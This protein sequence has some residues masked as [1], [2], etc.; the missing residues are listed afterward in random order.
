MQLIST[1]SYDYRHLYELD[2]HLDRFLRS[3]SMA[4]ISLPFDRSTIRSILIQTVAASNCT[5]G[6]LRYWLSAGPGN[7]LLS[8][9]GCPQPALYAVVIQSQSPPDL[10]GTKV[11]TSS[12]PVKS[13]RFAIMK[14]VNYLPNV[15]S[16][17]EAEES[18]AF[19]AIWLDDEGYVAEG[20]NMNVGFV[21]KE[22]E[23]VVPRFEKVTSHISPYIFLVCCLLCTVHVLMPFNTVHVLMSFNV[24]EV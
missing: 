13:P 10:K 21:T 7:F 3:A 12:I 4:K 9:S 23:F 16:K 24:E 20:P 22:R 17:M 19:A 14:S 18:D 11:I 2:Q 6:S 5:L 1:H 8:P 15:L